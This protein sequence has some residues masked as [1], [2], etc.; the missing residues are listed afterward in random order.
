MTA[1][2]QAGLRLTPCGCYRGAM[3]PHPF[4]SCG[5][6]RRGAAVRGRFRRL[7]TS[8]ALLPALAGCSS[9]SP[10]P[11]GSPTP[12]QT[13]VAAPAAAPAA[14]PDA[15]LTGVYPS[16]SLI[17]AFKSDS[18]PAQTS[19]VPHPPSTYTPVGQP[20]APPPGQP[21]Y[22]SAPAASAPAP[23]PANS[24]PVGSAMPYPQQSLS[25]L[26]SKKSDSQ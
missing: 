24:D 2:K 21:G 25:D 3:G 17:D 1:A 15:N 8:L 5:G 4:C 6:D 20:Y 7:A 16:V 23:P 26:F 13:A 22:G 18:P 12:Q 10:P 14:P 9:F 19:N 11:W